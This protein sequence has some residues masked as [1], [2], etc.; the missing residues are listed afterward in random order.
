ML[1]VHVITECRYKHV[2]V[3]VD[4]FMCFFMSHQHIKLN[5]QVEKFSFFFCETKAQQQKHLPNFGVYER[6]EIFNGH[7]CH[8][9][10]RWCVSWICSK[11]VLSPVLNLIH[12]FVFYVRKTED[13]I[14]RRTGCKFDIWVV[15]YSR[16]GWFPY[17]MSRHWLSIR[18]SDRLCLLLCYRI[19][20]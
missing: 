20:A 2:C 7:A 5:H 4:N 19:A 9:A 10:G 12:D 1:I 6:Y 14:S 18:M 8:I 16:H 17:K 11:Y 13:Y 15:G 3:C